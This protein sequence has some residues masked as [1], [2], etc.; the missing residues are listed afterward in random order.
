MIFLY[1]DGASRGNPGPASYGAVLYDHNMTV[2][3]EMGENLGIRTNNYAEY[4]GVI[5][6]LRYVQSQKL[7]PDVTIRMD[8]KLV[9]EQLAG[10]WKIKHPEMRELA[11]EASRLLS[12]LLVTFEWIPRELNSHA[13]ALGNR[14]LDEGD[15]ETGSNGLIAL[16]G[17]QPKSIRAPRQTTEPTTIV[18]VRHGHTA[19]T[20]GNLISGSNGEDPELSSL[21]VEEAKA[22]AR[23]TKVLLSRFGLSSPT[24][25]YHSPQLRTQ[26][27]ASY[28]SKEFEIEALPGP[29]FRE[30]GFGSWEGTGMDELESSSATEVDAWR[31]SM[32]LRPPGGESVAELEERVLSSLEEV[33]AD[34]SGE[35]A[36]IVTHMMPARAIARRALKASQDTAWSLQFSP[37]SVSIY[38]FFGKDLAEVFIL[39]SSSHLPSH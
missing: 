39:N 18:V 8:S 15:F 19:M 36:V 14:A 34:H 38:R 6:G 33:I 17:V 23:E 26:Q 21:G 30:I 7:G 1:A 31:G 10:R 9:I 35:C 24:A 32:T 29:N 28:F 11:A 37:A 5:A 3:A 27:S 2:I 22:A 4:Q 16:A 25:L 12:G 20:E 13:D